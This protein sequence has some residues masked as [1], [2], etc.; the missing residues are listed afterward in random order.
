M[1]HAENPPIAFAENGLVMAEVMADGSSL[2]KPSLFI[3]WTL[4]LF[5]I[6]AVL[7]SEESFVITLL[8]SHV[9]W[10]SVMVAL[11][12]SDSCPT[13]DV[14]VFMPRSNCFQSPLVKTTALLVFM[15][16]IVKRRIDCK[17]CPV[18]SWDTCTQTVLKA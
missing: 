11:D 7:F 9:I 16:L 12:E 2:T 8:V 1:L 5:L 18:M 17:L 13:G 14:E 10:M 4:S 15:L 6:S 3:A